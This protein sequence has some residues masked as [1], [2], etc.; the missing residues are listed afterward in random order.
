MRKWKKKITQA[1]RLLARG[2]TEAELLRDV[3]AIAR[4]LG[5]LVHHTHDS[6]WND[7]RSDKGV[8]DLTLAK[9]GRVVLIELKKQDGRVRPEQTVWL[10]A[11]GGFLIRPIDVMEG[12]VHQILQGGNNE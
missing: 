6:R 10:E 3:V 11:S 8:P 4:E 1:Q 7:W 12:T 2:Y 5:W 9:D